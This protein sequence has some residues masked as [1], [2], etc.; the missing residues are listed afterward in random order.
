MPDVWRRYVVEKGQGCH[1]KFINTL[2]HKSNK[3]GENL[4][5]HTCSNR[6]SL[7]HTN[8]NGIHLCASRDHT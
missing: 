7:V 4:T 5:Q 3:W 1:Q 2:N 6:V 8:R